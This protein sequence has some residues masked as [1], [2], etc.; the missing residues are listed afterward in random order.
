MYTL[1]AYRSAIGE[2]WSTPTGI[3][4][5]RLTRGNWTDEGDGC[6]KMRLYDDVSLEESHTYVAAQYTA[7]S[8]SKHHQ[9]H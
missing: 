7:T 9:P 4:F 2:P 1:V 6:E 8:T 5:F 3:P